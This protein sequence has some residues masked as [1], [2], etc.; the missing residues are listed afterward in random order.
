MFDW[1]V[2]INYFRKAGTDQYADYDISVLPESSLEVLEEVIT[3]DPPKASY[4][5]LKAPRFFNIKE[6][7]QKL[8]NSVQ[9]V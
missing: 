1:C 9:V 8:N 7:L 3:A 6:N 4:A 2:I 5:L